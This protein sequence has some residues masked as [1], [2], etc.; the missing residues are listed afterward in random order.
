MQFQQL[1]QMISNALEKEYKIVDAGS[2]VQMGTYDIQGSY[3][4]PQAIYTSLLYNGE[5]KAN[6]VRKM[7]TKNSTEKAGIVTG[8]MGVNISKLIAIAGK[9][10]GVGLT[11]IRKAFQSAQERCIHIWTVERPDGQFFMEEKFEQG[12]V[13]I[14]VAHGHAYAVVPKDAI[15]QDF[16]S[17]VDCLDRCWT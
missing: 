10:H 17:P 15:S 9:Y 12:D 13:H 11:S 2:S 14:V 4:V 5:I 16:R 7:S 6:T 8:L 1:A 3:C